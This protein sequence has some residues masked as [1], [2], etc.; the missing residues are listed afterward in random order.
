MNTEF[1][2]KIPENIKKAENQQP[3]FNLVVSEGSTVVLQASDLIKN[4]DT[5]SITHYS[6]N[7]TDGISL[8]NDNL[9]KENSSF[10]FTAPYVKGNDQYTRLGFELTIKDNSDNTRIIIMQMLLLNGYIELLYF[11]EEWHLE[12]TKLEYFSL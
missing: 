12:H 8:H 3:D 1:R 11:R 2:S 5:D 9:V 7:Q 6:W 10:S 4:I